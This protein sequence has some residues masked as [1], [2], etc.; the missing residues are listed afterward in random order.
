MSHDQRN[1]G[2]G[3]R[4]DFQQSGQNSQYRNETAGLNSNETSVKTIHAEVMVYRRG[5]GSPKGAQ[6][7]RRWTRESP[8]HVKDSL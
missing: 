2:R 1:V 5:I 4:K 7:R 3:F 6:N 8:G